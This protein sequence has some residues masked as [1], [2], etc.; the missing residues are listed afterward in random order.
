MNDVCNVPSKSNKQKSVQ[1]GHGYT[2]ME[3]EFRSSSL[4]ADPYPEG[5]EK[6]RYRTK[7]CAN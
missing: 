3:I 6:K 1:K 4:N 5:S 7:V 2:T